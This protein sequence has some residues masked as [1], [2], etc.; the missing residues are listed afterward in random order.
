MADVHPDSENV[1]LRLVG[2]AWFGPTPRRLVNCRVRVGAEVNRQQVADL[3][4]I[5]PASHNRVP[6]KTGQKEKQKLPINKGAAETA[7]VFGPSRCCQRYQRF[8]A[9]DGGVTRP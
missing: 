2:C 6:V 3:Q 4:P 7:V 9:E 1:R 8:D 5:S